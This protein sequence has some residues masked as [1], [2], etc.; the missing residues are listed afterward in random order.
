MN[1]VEKDDFAHAL[2][3]TLDFYGKKLEKSDF[4]FW[5]SAMGDRNVATIKNALKDYIKIGK[6]APRPANI[7]E[8][9][10]NRAEHG[11]QAL[12][13]PEMTTNCPPEIGKAWMWFIH[14]I[15][16]G[17]KNLDS[18]FGDC[19]KATLAEQEKYLHMVN[20]EARRCNKPDAIPEEYRLAEVWG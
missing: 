1:Q 5:Y 8:L 13:V 19:E 11:R 2:G 14:H 9:M 7:L 15:A 17:S 16:K 3:M 4:S 18:I 12:P 6:Y 10:Q 20:H